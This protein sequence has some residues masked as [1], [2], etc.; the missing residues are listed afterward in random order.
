MAAKPKRL[1]VRSFKLTNNQMSENSSGILG[2]L[3]SILTA[4]ST[5]EARKMKLSEAESDEDVMAYYKWYKNESLLF[6][7]MMCI[8]PAT[9]GGVLTPELL[10]KNTLTQEDVINGQDDQ[11]QIKDH[12]FFL[13]DDNYLIVSLPSSRSIERF[14]TYLNFLLEEKRTSIIDLQPVLVTA[15]DLGVKKIKSIVIGSQIVSASQEMN[16][17][18]TWLKNV[19]KELVQ[20][21]LKQQNS[22]EEIDLDQLISAELVIKI[23]NKAKRGSIKDS[24]KLVGA[25]LKPTTTD[26]GVVINTDKGQFKGHDVQHKETFEIQVTDAGNPIY[27]NVKLKMEQVLQNLRDKN[28][29]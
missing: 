12:F 10:C 25:L 14:Q 1:T 17:I 11:W 15:T 23:K 18:C 2:M 4:D 28:L 9:V 8:M 19:P 7:T 16:N 29:Q 5:I 26:S 13:T 21:I 24:E 22:L 27:E 3:K 6:G 20:S